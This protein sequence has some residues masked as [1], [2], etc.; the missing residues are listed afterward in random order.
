MGERIKRARRAAGLTQA[1]L[2][3]KLKL[4]VS[5]LA[6]WEQGRHKPPEWAVKLITDFIQKTESEQE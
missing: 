3:A 5:T 6:D 1:E 2:S 4:P